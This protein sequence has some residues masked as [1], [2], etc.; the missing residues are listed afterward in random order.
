V[1]L[2]GKFIDTK[3]GKT[4]IHINYIDTYIIELFNYCNTRIRSR[5]MVL[6]VVYI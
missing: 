1:D 4:N 3:T 2:D 6:F 5:T